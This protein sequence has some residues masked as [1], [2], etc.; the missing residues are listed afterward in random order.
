VGGKHVS[1]FENRY[2]AKDGS[3]KW[4]QW[5]SAPYP[6]QGLIYATARDVTDRKSAEDALRW[7]A[8]EMERA[9]EQQEQANE[10]LAQLVKELDVARERAER[11]AA[12]KSE[13]LANMS[14]EIRTPLNAVIGMTDL[15]L[16]TSLTPQQRDY[17]HT[18]KSSSEALLTIIDDIL[19]VSKIEGGRLTLDRAPFQVRDTV[20]AAVKLLA[21][22]AAEKG[23]RLTCRIASYVPETVVGDAGRLR[24][25]I[26]NLV[27]NAI[28]FTDQGEVTV[29]VSINHMSSDEVTLRFTVTDTGIG[30]APDKQWNIF[31]AFV[32]ADPSITRRYGGTGL[33]LTISAQLVEMMGGQVWIDSELGKGSRFHFIAKFGVAPQPEGALPPLEARLT[34]YTATAPARPSKRSR[35]A[36]PHS[37]TVRALV[38]E[39]NLTN[40]KLV[41][42]LLEQRGYKV[43]TVEDG[44]RAVER[45]AAEPFDV[46][47]MD[48]QMPEVGGLEATL[49]IRARERK[50]GG[51]TPIV[52]LTAFATPGDH[53][54]CRAVGMD[55]YLTKPIRPDELFTT[56]ESLLSSSGPVP[57]PWADSAAH[58]T[59][60]GALDR[61]GLL[62]SVGGNVKLLEGTLAVFLGEAPK[63]LTR[64]SDAVR[65][66][67]AAAVAAAAHAIKG[68]V[69]LFVQGEAF[70][71]ARRVEQLARAGDLATVDADGAATIDAVT[72]LLA[73]LRGLRRTLRPRRR[74]PTRRGS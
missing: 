17:L 29:D 36:R 2:L 16:Q 70:E 47:L 58:H 39:D 34:E 57:V 11:A 52:A 38:A 56:I 3:C 45:S 54:R 14:H 18:A 49:A 71:A 51:H 50:T 59:Y 19:D 24:Q 66:R 30:I 41:M 72:R 61:V 43:V 22:R 5:N 67:D 9:K 55:A 6:D 68:S 73:E 40:Q 69:G 64:L 33:G 12:A 44:R 32:Q 20:E 31:G 26:L 13:F 42:A 27:G 53:E 4:L 15:A 65:A 25:V 7:H 62:A 10:R 28:K 23:L 46:I 8:G 1:D 63:L 60:T 48:L 74:R 37:R 21:P 35:K